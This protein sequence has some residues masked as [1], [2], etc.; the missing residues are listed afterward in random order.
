LFHCFYTGTELCNVRSIET[1]VME[2][3]ILARMTTTYTKDEHN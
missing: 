2:D 1:A 3:S